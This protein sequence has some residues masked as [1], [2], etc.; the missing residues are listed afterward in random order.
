MANKERIRKEMPIFAKPKN[1]SGHR[2]NKDILS[3][4]MVVVSETTTRRLVLPRTPKQR[5]LLFPKN[6]SYETRKNT[7]TDY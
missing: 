5:V 1:T 6:T 7:A 3:L 2:P 4:C